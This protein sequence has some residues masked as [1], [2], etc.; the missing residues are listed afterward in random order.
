MDGDA[1]KKEQPSEI[2]SGGQRKDVTSPTPEKQVGLSAPAN[3]A[4]LQKR[5][6]N[7]GPE[8]S[9]LSPSQHNSVSN[10]KVSASG[11]PK[12]HNRTERPKSPQAVTVG[13]LAQK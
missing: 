4:T 6:P 5:G 12:G 2:V 8:K 9:Q 10:H 7:K 3:S 11:P 13:T 1:S